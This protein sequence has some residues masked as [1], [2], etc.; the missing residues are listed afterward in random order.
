SSP[1][2]D[3]DTFSVF[4]LLFAGYDPYAAG[5]MLGKLAMVSGGT[6]LLI[7]F[8]E[9]L[10]DPHTSFSNRL[11]KIFGVI[12]SACSTPAFSSFCRQYHDIVH[13]HLAAPLRAPTNTK[14]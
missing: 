8:W 14:N 2:L 13:P 9:I 6:N 12:R 5:G 11:D 1:E 4:A 7:Q 10:T 3:A